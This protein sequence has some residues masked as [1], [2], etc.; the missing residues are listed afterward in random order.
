LI[1]YLDTSLL[2][3]GLTAEAETRRI[4]TWLQERA[5]DDL[6]LSDW[7]VTEF[8]AALSTKLHSGQVTVTQRAA[9]LSVFSQ[10]C[11]NT[12]VVLP[13]SHEQFHTAARFA[14]QHAL[15]LRGGD[16]LHLAICGEYGATLCTLD[17]RLSEAGPP[18]G[19]ATLLL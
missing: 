3:A 10:F 2:V 16:A 17:R 4:Q 9:A 18:L 1:L 7:V 5:S 8:S 12:S 15:G 14:E 13:V 19:I 6:L 11:M